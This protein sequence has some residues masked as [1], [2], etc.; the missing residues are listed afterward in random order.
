MLDDDRGKALRLMIT[1]MGS[2]SC[3][4]LVDKL[5]KSVR[6]GVTI[7]YFDLNE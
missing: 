5:H 7:N 3:G 4:Q 2:S 1:L 6:F